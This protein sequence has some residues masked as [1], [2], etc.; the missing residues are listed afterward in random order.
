MRM[1]KREKVI[2]ALEVWCRYTTDYCVE[3]HCPYH[4]NGC[5]EQLHDDAIELLKKQEPRVMTLVEALAADYVYLDIRL[6]ASLP[7]DCCILAVDEDSNILTLKRGFGGYLDGKEYDK[8]WRCWT[9]KPTD[10]QREATP[11]G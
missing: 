2:H 6:H 8:L 11:C 5:I 1:D 7:C 3:S 4:G 9:S 10:A